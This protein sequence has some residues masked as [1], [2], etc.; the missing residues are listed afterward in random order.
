MKLFSQITVIIF[1]SFMIT[2]MT[3]FDCDQN[4]GCLLKKKFYGYVS[5]ADTRG[6]GH[7]MESNIN[8][9]NVFIFK[10]KIVFY[11]AKLPQEN[12]AE[13]EVQNLNPQMNESYIERLIPFRH[14]ILECGKYQTRICHTKDLPKISQSTEY[15]TIK[16]K[17]A[18]A[19]DKCVAFTF[20]EY[21]F[22]KV[23]E[24]IAVMCVTDSRQV[25][26][27]IAFK[28]FLSNTVANYHLLE[29][30]T[31]YDA[32][33]GIELASGHF[34]SYIKSK[35]IKVYASL[36]SK[37]IYLTTDD[38]KKEYVKN[39]KYIGLRNTGAFSVKKANELKKLKEG[40]ADKL[41]SPPPESCCIVLPG[42]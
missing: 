26:E 38:S 3:C 4:L 8:Y 7:I 10:D 39:I 6:V 25:K 11:K 36:R 23:S 18:N 12:I 37:S 28:N 42:K 32:S 19:D 17:I 35:P 41:S 30:T 1:I 5:N 29:A 14:L 31:R 9:K 27:L 33:S 13:Q 16:T 15:T 24:K 34:I 22:Q 20:Y 40:W 2:D 21:S